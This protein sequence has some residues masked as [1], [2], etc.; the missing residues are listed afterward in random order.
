MNDLAGKV[1]M[2]TG[3]NAGL[4]LGIA[5]GVATASLASGLYSYLV[6]RDGP[7]LAQLLK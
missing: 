2:V 5:H 7:R 6:D 1:K 3:G 4:S